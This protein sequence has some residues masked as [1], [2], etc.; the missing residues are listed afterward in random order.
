MNY[1]RSS[2]NSENT[3]DEESNPPQEVPASQHIETPL[4]REVIQRTR[5]VLHDFMEKSK[6][7]IHPTTKIQNKSPSIS[8]LRVIIPDKSVLDEESKY[9]LKRIKINHFSSNTWYS[10]I[11][12]IFSSYWFLPCT[13]IFA[14][15]YVFSCDNKRVLFVIHS[16]NCW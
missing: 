7:A 14:S 3:L 11:R 6:L 5:Q 4:T 12:S 8:T 15:I 16:S 13:L 9:S 2:S 1:P 10:I